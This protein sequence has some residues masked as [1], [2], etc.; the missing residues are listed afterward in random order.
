MVADAPP[1]PPGQRLATRRFTSGRPD[2]DGP[3]SPEREKVRRPGS[4]TSPGRWSLML[5]LEPREGLP[6]VAGLITRPPRTLSG[7][8]TIHPE[9]WGGRTAHR[10]RTQ[11]Q[12]QVDGVTQDRT[13]H[14][15]PLLSPES[16]VIVSLCLPSRSEISCARLERALT[17]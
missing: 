7:R 2:F 9:S 10:P 5:L 14:P 13:P 3:P 12:P 11:G 15:L 8:E 17:G 6:A 1:P 16:P 4:H